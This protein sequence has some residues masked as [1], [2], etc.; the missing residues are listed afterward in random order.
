MK[1][2]HIKAIGFDWDGTLVDSMKIKSEAFADSVVGFYPNLINHKNKIADI[3]ISSRG[4]P[5]SYQLGL[6]QKKYNLSQLDKEDFKR[7]SAVFNSLYID[8]KI[9]LF[10]DAEKTLD[11]LKNRGY[12]LF[13]CS[14]V[15]QVF[16]D[17][18]LQLYS[19]RSYFQYILGLSHDGKFRKGPPHLAYITKEMKVPQS[20]IAFIGDSGDDVKGAKEAG[21]FSIGK[22]DRRNLNAKREI[23]E[24]RPNLTIEKLEEL[25]VYF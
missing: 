11:Q 15:P 20:E 17:K 4:N 14:S 3:Y 10:S 9:P 19:I 21:C 12:K 2:N 24:S 6:I 22:I 25:L 23:E 16:L 5:R 1:L 13:L 8:K 7:W 18:T